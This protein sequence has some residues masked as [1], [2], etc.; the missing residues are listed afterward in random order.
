MTRKT[1][2]TKATFTFLKNL[3]QNNTK[4]WFQEHRDEY[5]RAVRVPLLTF[6]QDL[7]DPLQKISRFFTSDSR[8]V[9]GSMFRIYRD[10]RFSKDK[11]PYKTNAGA[12]FRHEDGK[13]AH[14]PGYYL[15]LEPGNVFGGAGIWQPDAKALTEIREAIVAKPDQWEKSL[16]G[17]IGRGMFAWMG[18]SLKRVP[19][20][21][22]PAHPF[23]ADLKRKDY[24]IS[25]PFTEVAAC[26]NDFM[27]QYIQFCESTSDYMAFLT[28]ALHLPF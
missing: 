21:F 22:D 26:A 15:H 27:E 8:P 23:V 13:N 28:R 17:I 19:K 25:S 6:I 5:E 24:A 10:T 16:H 7:A 9:G 18:E 4:Q 11:S 3:K 14:A 1:Y 12:H 2:F 20:G